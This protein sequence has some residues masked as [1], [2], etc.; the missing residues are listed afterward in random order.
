V[1]LDRL[2]EFTKSWEGLRLHAYL[3]PAAIPTI[4][5]GATGA[6]VRLGLVW[7]PEQAE[8]RLRNDLARSVADV[9][10]LCPDIVLDEG[11]MIAVADFCFN[12]GEGR[13]AGSTLRRRI[14]KRD[15]L[16]AAAQ[17]PQWV[18][19]GA[20][21]LPGLVVR[22]EA[23]RRLFLSSSPSNPT[24]VTHPVDPPPFTAP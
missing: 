17:F 22:R 2:V 4:G 7:T 23:E 19:A 13:L 12:L 10:R 18:R 9:C 24:T 15:W 21:V 11:K 3:C 5:Y 14:A 6:D 20:Q 8:E 16:G 1:N